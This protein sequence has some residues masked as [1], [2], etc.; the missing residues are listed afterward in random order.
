VS[1]NRREHPCKTAE[2]EESERI[3][4]GQMVFIDDK[5][6]QQENKDPQENEC[7]LVEEQRQIFQWVEKRDDFIEI[8][9]RQE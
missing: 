8:A 2:K 3:G 1:K 4:L 7:R 6:N 9:Q 5:I